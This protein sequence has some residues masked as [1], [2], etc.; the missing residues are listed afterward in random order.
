[1]QHA[2]PALEKKPAARPAR[3]QPEY[4]M[5]YAPPPPAPYPPHPLPSSV[6]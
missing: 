4:R 5:G 3:S 2:L 1:M 6:V